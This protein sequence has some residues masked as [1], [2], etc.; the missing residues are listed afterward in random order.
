MGGVRLS[1]Y[2]L[3]GLSTM[4]DAAGRK[5][6]KGIVRYDVT[7]QMLENRC[8]FH[9]QCTNVTENVEQDD[10]DDLLE[11]I[12]GDHGHH[13]LPAT[14]LKQCKQENLCCAKCATHHIVNTLNDFC[15][16]P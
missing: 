1:K 16:S 11:C 2:E 7:P 13:L 4:D 6:A 5:K 8:Q 14:P 10:K 9:P 12:E 3:Q 15:N